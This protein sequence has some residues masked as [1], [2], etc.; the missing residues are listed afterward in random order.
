DL[1]PA[2]LVGLFVICVRRAEQTGRALGGLRNVYGLVGFAYIGLLFA[3]LVLLHG[4]PGQVRVAP[5]W[6]GGRGAWL[7]RLV[8]L[9]VWGPDTFA[10]FVGKS[11]G[12]HKLAPKLSPAKTVEGA[13]GGFLG[14]TLTGA[15][16][17]FWIHLPL[18]HGL[19]LGAMVGIVGQIGD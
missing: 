12:R 2:L 18:L 4:L 1:L 13:L 14:A 6:V 3:S 15:A 17:A 5:F 11:F 10:Y 9:S 8:V 19:I 7:V 16:F